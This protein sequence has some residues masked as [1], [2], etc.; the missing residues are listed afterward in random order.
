[1][2]VGARAI[3]DRTGSVGADGVVNRLTILLTMELDGR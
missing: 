3:V 1:M 2:S